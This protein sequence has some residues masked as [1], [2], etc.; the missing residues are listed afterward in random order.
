MAARISGVLSALLIAA[1]CGVVRGEEMPAAEIERL[2]KLSG[3][4][5]LHA[6]VLKRLDALCPGG[7]GG[8]YTGEVERDAQRMPDD[9]QAA[10]ALQQGTAQKVGEFIARD[11]VKKGGGCSSEA[12]RK[13][14]LQAEENHR[15]AL[16]HWRARGP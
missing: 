9:F 5:L 1:W 6:A 14:R 11:F 2:G 12:V 4:V 8:D 3:E 7:A 16:R 10:F 13:A 15:E